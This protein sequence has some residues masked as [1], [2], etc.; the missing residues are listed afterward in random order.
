MDTKNL[1][2]RTKFVDRMCHWT[3]V[4]CFFLV[5]MS[6]LSWFF[7][8]LNWLSGVLGTP[9]LARMLHPFLGTVVFVLLVCMF[10]R[11]VHYNMPA[12]TDVTWFRN[13]ADVLMNRHTK[14]L[15]IGKYNAGQKILFWCIMALISALF[16]TGVVA[17]RPY[18]AGYFPIPAIRLALLA[19]SLA[20]LGLI[21]LV[22]GH[23]YMGIWVR[24][25]I[26]G[27]LTGYVS[28]AWAKQHHDRWY[29]E[30]IAPAAKDT[31]AKRQS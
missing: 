12:R 2:L 22:I 6:G 17:W 13:I 25:S 28:R 31:S 15:G 10:F 23:I 18:F 20:G 30:E 8:S 1:I 21:L 4:A 14:P 7:P 29:A 24:G 26:T 3:M 11:F 5:A 9:Q 16:A 19:H 27:M